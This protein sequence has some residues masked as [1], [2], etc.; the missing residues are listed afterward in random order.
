[1]VVGK[2]TGK[3]K[4]KN[5]WIENRKDGLKEIKDLLSK[6]CDRLDCYI[7]LGIFHTILGESVRGWSSILRNPCVM[8]SID[9]ETSNKF[10]E[11]YAKLVEEYIKLDI[12]FTK[13]VS[14]ILQENDR[15]RDVDKS[16]EQQEEMMRYVA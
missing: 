2:M 1:M 9:L 6:P 10:L 16:P 12:E 5:E 11:T 14:E 4:E 13:I 3:K 7:N 15:Y 8:G